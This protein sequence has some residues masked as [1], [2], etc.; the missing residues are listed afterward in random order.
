M[1]C[2]VGSASPDASRGRHDLVVNGVTIQDAN[3]LVSFIGNPQHWIPCCRR[4]W[5]PSWSSGSVLCASVHTVIESN[6]R[7]VTSFQHVIPVA[8]KVRASKENNNAAVR[9]PD[10]LVKCSN[11]ETVTKGRVII[12]IK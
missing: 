6:D 1:V 3:L 7:D 11:K 8:S 4:H 5:V 9:E 2:G 12:N 10:K